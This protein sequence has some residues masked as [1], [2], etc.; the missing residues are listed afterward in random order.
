MIFWG[1]KVDG[2]VSIY[3]RR[4]PLVL[5]ERGLQAVL[6]MKQMKGN[7]LYQLYC[8]R[9]YQNNKRYQRRAYDGTLCYCHRYIFASFNLEILHRFHDM[10]ATKNSFLKR[11]IWKWKQVH[12]M[13]KTWNSFQLPLKH[14]EIDRLNSKSKSE[15]NS[16]MAYW[17]FSDSQSWKYTIEKYDWNVTAENPE[18][19]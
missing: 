13:E 10:N 1:G 19:F 3:V 5:N 14:L 18:V 12:F 16:A 15:M 4:Q 11:E 8:I 17:C 7:I 6:L 2:G 9:F